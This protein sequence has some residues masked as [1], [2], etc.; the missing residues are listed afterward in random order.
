MDQWDRKM[1]KKGG[2][3]WQSSQPPSIIE[4]P[5]PGLTFLPT[6]IIIIVGMRQIKSAHIIN[7]MICSW[8]ITVFNLYQ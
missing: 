4:V 8:G 5:P 7:T 1:P 2:E 3:S 6:V